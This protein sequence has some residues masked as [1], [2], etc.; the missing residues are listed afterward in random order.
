MIFKHIFG[1]YDFKATGSNSLRFVNMVRN[2]SF[3]VHNLYCKNNDV[4]G[5]IYA[6]KYPQL[7]SI[8]SKNYMDI[9]I[10]SKKG[11]VF[12]VKPYKKRFGIITGIIL[13]LIIIFILSNTALKIR[14]TG[15][16]EELY[17]QI[18]SVLKMNGISPGKY[19]PNMNFDQAEMNIVLALKDIAWVSIRNSGGIITVNV[20]ECTKKPDMILNRLPCNIVSLKDAQIVDVKVYAGQLKVL[21]GEGVKKG[22]LL[23]SGFIQNKNGEFYYYHSQAEII[24]RYTEEISFEQPFEDE[25]QIPS[26]KEIKKKY[27]N[28]FSVKIPL[29]FKKEP[30]GEYVYDEYT[31]NFSFFKFKLPMGVSH[32]TYKPYY[33][34]QVKYT[35]DEVKEKLNEKMIIYE[36]DFL[37]D[38]QII[39]REINEVVTNEKIVYNVKYTVEGDI[40]NT[41]E[42]LTKKD[43]NTLF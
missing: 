42:I 23:V 12:R 26:N 38:S 30:V 2:Q 9:Q 13:S 28:F 15:C 6:T 18:E 17:P 33:T 40:T 35:E 11:L 37:R 39:S 34:K 14:I 43:N 24:G 20:N 25:V 19:I 29:S 4:F 22:D 36:N 3:T 8:A 21:I 7:K 32:S 31:N 27:F 10:V 1:V 5:R 16:E 41:N